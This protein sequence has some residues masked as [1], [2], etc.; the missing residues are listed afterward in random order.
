M[1][2]ADSFLLGLLGVAATWPRGMPTI[3]SCEIK[4]EYIASNKR[5]PSYYA[6]E[7]VSLG[8]DS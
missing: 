8:V 1:G 6:A 5:K 7:Q 4:F 3:F 2:G